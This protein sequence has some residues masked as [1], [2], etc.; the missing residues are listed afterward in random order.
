M[1]SAIISKQKAIKLLNDGYNYACV[2]YQDDVPTRF[3]RAYR[4]YGEAAERISCYKKSEKYDVN[5]LITY[6]FDDINY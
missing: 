3:V 4:T 5:R 2:K 6:V 1:R